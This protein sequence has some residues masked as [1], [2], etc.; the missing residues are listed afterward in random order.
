MSE[1][2][3]EIAGII[4]VQAKCIDK[5]L[6]L[7]PETGLTD[8]GERMLMKEAIRQVRKGLERKYRFLEKPTK[9]VLNVW[10]DRANTAR[11]HLAVMA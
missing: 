6:E 4:G 11:V 9:A 7:Y 10:I 1:I 8:N 5:Y 3:K 2:D